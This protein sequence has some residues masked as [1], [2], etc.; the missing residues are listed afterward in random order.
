MLLVDVV[1]YDTP[2]LDT[3]L[4]A[5]ELLRDPSHVRDHT[6]DQWLAMLAAAGFQAAV[7]TEWDLRIDF[8]SWVE[9]MMTPAP[10]VAMLRTLLDQAPAEVRHALNVEADSSFTLR[11]ALLRAT[12]ARE[13]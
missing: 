1:S 5:I 7:D 10:A 12:R 11:C 9:R 8:T 3:H 2:V 4:Q 13:P 6:T